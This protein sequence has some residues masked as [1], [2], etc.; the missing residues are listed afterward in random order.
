MHN[1]SRGGLAE[2]NFLFGIDAQ[3]LEDTITALGGVP[4]LVRAIRSLD[5]PGRVQ[6]HLRLKQRERGFDQAA[7]IE[8]FVVLNTP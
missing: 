2:D 7:Y 1:K 3:P 5:V 4:Q 6:L 8:S